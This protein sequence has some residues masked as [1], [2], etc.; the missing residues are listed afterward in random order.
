M[1]FSCYENVLK[2]TATSIYYCV[3]E[4]LQSCHLIEKL[5]LSD[6][7]TKSALHNICGAE[8]SVKASKLY[9]ACVALVEQ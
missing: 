8:L 7:M 2:A 4:P 5:T 1:R 3:L 9:D 6:F